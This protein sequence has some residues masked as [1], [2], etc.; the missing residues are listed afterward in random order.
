MPKKKTTEQ[1]VKEVS[2]ILGDKYVVLG[3]YPGCHGKVP[4]KHLVCGNTFNKNVHDIISKHSGCP[5]CNGNRS[6]KY[7]E[8][9]VKDNTPAPYQYVSGYNGMKQKC[10]FFCNI[11]KK[12]FEQMP[13]RLINQHI[14]GCGCSPTKKKTNKEF[15]SELGE[16][17]LKEFEFLEEYKNIDTKIKIKHKKCGTVFEL[18]PYKLIYRHNK[19]YCPICYYKKSHGE[20]EIAAFLEN[21]KINYYREYAFQDLS[22]RKFDFYLPEQN[23]IIEFDGEQHFKPVDFF[24]GEDS[25]KD[26]QKRDYEKNQ[27]CLKNKITVFRIP[28]TQINNIEKILSEILEEKRSTTIEK[29]LITE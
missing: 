3:E 23:I 13:S 12:E 29:F 5:Y 27:Y 28:Y 24:G 7:N 10:K 26:L 20:I 9:W 14:Y 8:Q 1:F 22:N 21:K 4:M 15:L 16:E 2:E 25:F 6:A 18:S 11:C 19:K 17:C